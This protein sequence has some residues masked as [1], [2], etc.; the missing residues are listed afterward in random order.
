MATLR[1]LAGSIEIQ[2]K[3]VLDD[4]E[5]NFPQIVFW[6]SFFI[7][8]YRYQKLQIIDSGSFLSIFT[9][10]PVSV[11]TSSQ[12]PNQVQ[13]RKYFVLPSAIYDLD[14]DAGIAYITYSQFDDVCLPSWTGITF[15]RTTPAK[16]QRLY[17]NDFEKPK[18]DNP[19]FYR[20]G[21][22]VYLLGLECVNITSLEVGLLC[23]FN[24]LDDCDLDMEINEAE[25]LDYITKGVL[26]LG[27]FALLIPSNT[28]NLGTP[29]DTETGYQAR[30]IQT[31]PVQPAQYPQNNN[32]IQ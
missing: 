25:M 9:S 2:L 8:K 17:M 32:N 11:F 31:A 10:V 29:Q 5:I 13:E 16:A 27:R 4:S 19:Y 7:N 23:P 28:T 22:Y 1:Q 18:T 30:A 24:P 26:D 14:G 12:N 6:C 15:S 20:V 21:D 3:Q